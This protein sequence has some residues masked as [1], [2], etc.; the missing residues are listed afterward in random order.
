MGSECLGE[1][2]TDRVD[3][4]QCGHGFL[5]DHCYLGTTDLLQM[6]FSRTEQFF[7]TK[8]DR[9]TNMGGAGQ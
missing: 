2:L 7:A 1:Q 6:F 8:L 4:V 9:S 5:K 3:G